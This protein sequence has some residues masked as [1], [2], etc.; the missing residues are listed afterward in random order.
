MK[1]YE[2]DHLVFTLKDQISIESQLENAK[3]TLSLKYDYNLFDAFRL[4]D[5]H[6]LG[7]FNKYDL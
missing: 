1:G 7:Y 3:Q 6:N 2:E 4:F 5:K